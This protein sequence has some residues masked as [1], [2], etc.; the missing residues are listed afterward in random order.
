MVASKLVPVN[1]ERLE[2]V[3]IELCRSLKVKVD[4]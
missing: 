1:S 4:S 3:T 2:V